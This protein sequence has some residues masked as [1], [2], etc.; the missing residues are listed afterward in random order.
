MGKTMVRWLVLFFICFAV[1]ARYFI[2]VERLHKDIHPDFRATAKY[3]ESL[4]GKKLDDITIGYVDEVLPFGND[5]YVTIGLAN[6]VI[7]KGAEIDIGF[8]DYIYLSPEQKDWLIL[9]ELGHA[10]CHLPHTDYNENKLVN[11]FEKIAVFINLM[12][13]EQPYGDGCPSHMMTTYMPNERCAKKHY[14]NYMVTLQ[15]GCK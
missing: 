11:F 10:V 14:M 9:H 5:K 6:A 8:Y 1:E 3:F 12:V 13:I 7:P 2:R 4:T 15:Q